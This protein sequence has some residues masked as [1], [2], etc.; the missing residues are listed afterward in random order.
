MIGVPFFVRF[1]RK[2][3]TYYITSQPDKKNGSIEI[4]LEGSRHTLIL[5]GQRMWI[6]EVKTQEKRLEPQ[7]IQMIGKFV[8]KRFHISIS[9]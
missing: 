1:D 4:L 5:D 3:Y 6:E 8:I 2:V 9:P 7:L